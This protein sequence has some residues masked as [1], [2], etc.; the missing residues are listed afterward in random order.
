MVSLIVTDAKHK[1]LRA[2]DDYMLDLAYGSDENSF[3]LTCLPQP[4]AGALIIIDGT[5]YGGLVTVRNTDGSVEGPTWHGL[6]SR[7]I[8]QPD[9][10][11]DYLTVSGAAGDV[12]NMLFKRIGLDALFTASARHAVTIGS[13]SFDRYT[14]AYTGIR[15]MLAANNA[16]L[17]LIWADGRVNAYALPAEHYGDSIDSDLLE[18]KA[19]LDSQPVNHLIGLGTGELKDRAVVHWYADVNGNVS[20]TQSLTGLAERQ[21]V[22]DYS[23]AKPDEL[24][25]ETRKKLIELQSQGGVEVTITDNTL[26]MDIG[27]TVTGRD[28]RLGITLTVPVAKK[29]VK[30][31]GGILSVD[32]ECGTAS[33]D[34]TS[35]SGSAES[36]GSTGSGGSGTYYADG[37]TITMRNN[38]FS[39]VVTPSRVDDVEKTAK[40]AYTL[41]SN[42]SAEIGKAQQDSIAAIAAA[43]MNVASITTATPL[44]AS[45]NGQAVHITA[46]EATA[47]GSG[48]MSAADKR[49]LDGLDT[50]ALPA[51]TIATLG[52]VRPDG[53]TITVNEDGV[54]TAHA[55]STGNG[56]LFPVGYVVM[57]TTGS[58]PANDFGGVWEERPSLGAHMWERT[59]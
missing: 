28:N 30:S 54:I 16:K 14:D 39:A 31:S 44:S 6:L 1:P 55:T 33:G 7:R 18:F 23:N 24:N 41:A 21:A 9:T 25:T 4:E 8:L 59:G 52:G 2:V 51:A 49:K 19:S 11:R 13:Y 10:G 12:L 27:D 34:T 20:Q 26:S 5:E 36:N 46:T 22:Y 29:V 48:L 57:N 17:R 43:A 53:S 32:Y 45:R 37:V 47:E 56:I 58:D 40:D 38:T 50:Y 15:K 42:Y 3:K 35:L